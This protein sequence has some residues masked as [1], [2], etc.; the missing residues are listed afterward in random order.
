MNLH[1]D[2]KHMNFIS[3]ELLHKSLFNVH[4]IFK[5]IYSSDKIHII[6]SA[7]A[8]FKYYGISSVDKA[9]S[10]PVNFIIHRDF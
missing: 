8:S 7:L 9:V 6:L 3:F 1:N 10:K 5:P 4:I 2:L